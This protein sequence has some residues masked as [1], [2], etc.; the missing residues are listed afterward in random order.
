MPMFDDIV[1][2]CQHFK[3]TINDD[4]TFANKRNN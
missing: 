2:I 4:Y 1:K 3:Q